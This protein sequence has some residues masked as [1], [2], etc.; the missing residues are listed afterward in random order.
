MVLL[1]ETAKSTVSFNY[2][3]LEKT[4]LNGSFYDSNEVMKPK[5][6]LYECLIL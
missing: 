2:Y 3:S 6:L 5:I 4:V 1:Q